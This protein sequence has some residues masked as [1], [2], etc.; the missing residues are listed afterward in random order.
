MLEL[1][2]IF[3]PRDGG[4]PRA[5]NLRIGDLRP[6]PDGTWSV[7]VDILGFEHEDR[8]RLRQV[9]WAHAIRDAAQFVVSLVAGKVE[10]AGGGTLDP[11]I[12][13]SEEKPAEALQENRIELLFSTDAEGPVSVQ[14]HAPRPRPD[15]ERPW[16]V[17]VDTGG[18]LATVAGSDPLEALELAARFA[19]SYLSGR[20]GLTPEINTL[21]LQEA[22]DLLAQGFREGIFAVLEVRGIACPDE[23]RGRI[24]AIS[25][26][27]ALQRM[28]GRA[29]TAPTAGDIF[30][31]P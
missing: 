13:I 18:Q 2:T 14:I 23:A 4:A 24:A 26:P 22:P 27:A 9:D 16:G 8:V 1:A 5:I 15:D 3:T 30:D 21:P 12:D 19:A 31:D 29:K 10:R 17:K 7:A 28:L 6:E 25:E 11:P 20:E